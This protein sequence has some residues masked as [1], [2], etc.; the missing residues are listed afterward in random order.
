[1]ASLAGASKPDPHSSPWRLI[2]QTIGQ[3]PPSL[4]RPS[5]LPPHRCFH[6]TP[7]VRRGEEGQGQLSGALNREVSVPSFTAL[8]PS[9]LPSDSPSRPL[10]LATD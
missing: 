8:N 2:S 5:P 1:M 3:A 6:I 4:S 10:P 9:L 7:V